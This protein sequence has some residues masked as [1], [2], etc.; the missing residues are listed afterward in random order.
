MQASHGSWKSPV[1]AAQVAGASVKLEELQLC[2]GAVYWTERR[3]LEKG[4]SVLMRWTDAEGARA[5]TPPLFS[6]RTRVHEYGGGAFLASPRGVWFANDADQGWYLAGTDGIQPLLVQP[7]VRYAEPALWGDDLIV[8][9]EDHTGGGEAQNRLERVDLARGTASVLVSGEDFFS[10]VA[11]RPQDGRVAWLSWNH[12]DMPWDGTRLWWADREGHTLTTPTPLAGPSESIFQPQWAPDGSLYFISDRSGWWNLWRWDGRA[13]HACVPMQ[14]EFGRPQ[15]I[16]GL[17]TY[18]I[19]SDGTVVC[20]WFSGDRWRLGT[21]TETDGLKPIETEYTELRQVQVEGQH[22]VLLADSPTTSTAILRLDVRARTLE[23][24]RPADSQGD[25]RYYSLPVPVDFPNRAGGE[26][27]AWFYPPRNPDFS[28]PPSE[29]PPLLVKSHG[30]P[31]AAASTSLSLEI[32]YWT[33]RGVAVLDVNYRGSTGYG[34][35]YR[36]ALKGQWGVADVE[37]CADGARHLVAQGLVDGNRLA[38]DG[39]SA[40]GYTTLAL[41]TFTNVFKAGASYYGVSNLEA[42]AQDTHKFESRY[43]DQLVGPYPQAIDVYRARSPIGHTDRLNCPIILF[44]GL[45]DKVVP[46]DQSEQMYQAVRAKGLPVAY[47][48]FEGEQ[49]GF[50]QSANI[51]RALQAEFLF[52]A[53]VFGFCP[54]DPLPDIP[55]ENLS[56]DTKGSPC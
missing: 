36:D 42:L 34:R 19:A 17:S 56:C 8:V 7:G 1:T 54:A 30:G 43:T 22:A 10:S 35:A 52:F 21:W 38:V 5:L 2:G 47:L 51:E 25:V 6:V 9:A 37:D 44:Q 39:R 18:G 3:P 40:G 15:W 33:S 23:T 45:E 53:R 12:P 50:R 16:F 48:T 55:I 4:R 32:Q 31:T 41:L 49:H 11:V 13:L 46:P 20:T 24:V 27:H 28:A 26:S 14:A 29:R